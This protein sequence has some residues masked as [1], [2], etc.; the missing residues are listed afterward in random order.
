MSVVT[1]H[2]C[3][4][5]KSMHE[6]KIS[7]VDLMNESPDNCKFS[8]FVGQ[9]QSTN[10]VIPDTLSFCMHFICGWVSQRQFGLA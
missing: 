4:C 3:P 9:L 6:C 7:S 2:V 5:D 10:K 8:Q 1:E